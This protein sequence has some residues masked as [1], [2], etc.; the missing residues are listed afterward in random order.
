[1]TPYQ[2]LCTST[3][4]VGKYFKNDKIGVIN[5]GANADLL[6]L[7]ANPLKDIRATSAI[8]GVMLNGRWLSKTEIDNI[9]KKLVK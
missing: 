5:T 7:N 2:A 9:L 8:D 4:N 3:L 6:L 1:M